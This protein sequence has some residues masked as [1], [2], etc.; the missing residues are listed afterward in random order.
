MDKEML[1]TLLAAMADM[2]DEMRKGFA[3]INEKIDVMADDI[4]D[5]KA[6]I[7]IITGT[8]EKQDRRIKKLERMITQ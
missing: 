2:K 8:A 1:D 6:D 5:I 7:K 3:E 4:E